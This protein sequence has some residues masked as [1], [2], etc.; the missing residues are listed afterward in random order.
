MRMRDGW[1]RSVGA[2][3]AVL[4]L[5]AC[6]I[7]MAATQGK[8]Y[9]AA[10]RDPA[11]HCGATKPRYAVTPKPSQAGRQRGSS[12]THEPKQGYADPCSFGASAKQAK[13]NV[14]LIGD[15]HAAHW[16]TA[17]NAV[18]VK[19]RWRAFA[20]TRNSCPFSTGGR[21]IPEPDRSQCAQ[22]KK[23]VVTWLT[24][25]SKVSTVFLAQEVS[26]VD[27]RGA[28]DPFAYAAKSYVDQWKGLPKSVKR[29]VVIRD[30]PV[31]RNGTLACVTKA[32]A[33][34]QA[35]GQACAIPRVE[36]LQPDPAVAAAALEH[37][38]R[39][40]SIDLSSFFCDTQSCFPVV[41]GVLVYLDQNHL[42]PAFVATV[43][44][45]LDRKF[46]QLK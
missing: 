43:A 37:S 17:L 18:A 4:F 41:G 42:T 15:S 22:W 40:Q 31:A 11:H 27:T 9:G 1:G 2:L 5:G 23:D 39:F 14:A 6:G 25:H 34:K 46:R 21:P 20:I 33:R 12:C 36:A 29:V 45:Y 26:D 8:C 10:A 28:A 30:S 7:A 24:K 3:V 19:E 35:P 32:V 13:R 16:R 38:A 44:P